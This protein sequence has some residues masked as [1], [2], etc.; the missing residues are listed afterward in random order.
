MRLNRFLPVLVLCAGGCATAPPPPPAGAGAPSVIAPS[1]PLP[2]TPAPPAAPD[3]VVESKPLTWSQVASI[4][5]E[6]LIDVFPGMPQKR[7]EERM[8]LQSAGRP[9]NPFRQEYLRDP[10]GRLYHVVFYLTRE[11][12]KGRPIN[13]RY[14]TPVIFSNDKVEA[15][16]RY[17]LKK[18]RANA[19]RLAGGRCLPTG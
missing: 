15:I 3:P 17:P 4:N 12:V 14:L 13:E 6:R 7:V 19:C 2:A 16:G 1:A 9:V 11:P 8:Q 5:D 10:R 18:L